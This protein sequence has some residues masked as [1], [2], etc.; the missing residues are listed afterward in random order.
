M[1]NI[2]VTFCAIREMSQRIFPRG[3]QECLHCIF[4]LKLE[5]PL[6]KTRA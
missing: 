1:E 5:D 3:V 6:V 2:N 4:T